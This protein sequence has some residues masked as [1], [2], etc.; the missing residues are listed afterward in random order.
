MHKYGVKEI[1]K[2]DNLASWQLHNK[3]L[4]NCIACCRV[5]GMALGK[6]RHGWDERPA[7]QSAIR[8][9]EIPIT[10]SQFGRALRKASTPSGVTLLRHR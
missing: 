10:I 6:C 5:L 3:L 9:Q 8:N 1:P 7:I 2:T 4:R